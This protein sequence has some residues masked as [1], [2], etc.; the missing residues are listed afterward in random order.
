M[1]FLLKIAFWLAVVLVLLP[2]VGPQAAPKSAQ[3]DAGEAVSAASAAVADLRQFC[4]RQPDACTIGSQ[5]A[6][7]LGQRAQIG[8]KMLYEFLNEHLPAGETGSVTPA[9]SKPAATPQNTLTP[10]DVTT[11]WRG[12]APRNGTTVAAKR[13]A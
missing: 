11:P 4:A 13:P 9:P 7:V 10:A 8:A 2:F 3:V 1:R 6:T 12:P 5:A